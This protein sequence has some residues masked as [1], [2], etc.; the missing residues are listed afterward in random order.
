MKK[1]KIIEEEKNDELKKE[2]ACL[3]YNFKFNNKEKPIST[4]I[5]IKKGKI[6]DFYNNIN[7]Y[8]EK[9]ALTESN[10]FQ[11][12]SYGYYRHC[13]TKFLEEKLKKKTIKQMPK[14]KLKHFFQLHSKIHFGS[15][16]NSGLYLKDMKILIN[17]IISNQ[18]FQNRKIFLL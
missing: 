6:N 14:K 13:F 16:I 3:F 12:D 9:I 17:M 4:H 11:R 1:S 10:S 18:K 5:S 2:T 7:N 8:I 15:F